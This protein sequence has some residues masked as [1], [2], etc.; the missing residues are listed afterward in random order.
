M[1]T[2]TR[3]WTQAQRFLRRP[4]KI[5]VPILTGLIQAAGVDIDQCLVTTGE[6]Q[7]RIQQQALAM[8]QIQEYNKRCLDDPTLPKIFLISGRD[9]R[10]GLASCYFLGVHDWSVAEYGGVF[11]H[12]ITG[13]IIDN[14]ALAP[15]T[16]LAF[17]EV[18][19]IAETIPDR[20]PGLRLYRGKSVMVT[21]E[22]I[23][24]T[25]VAM[26]ILVGLVKSELQDYENIVDILASQIAVDILPKG[27]NKGVGVQIRYES[28]LAVVQ[29]SRTLVIDDSM[30]GAAAATM[31]GFAGC[32]SNATL[33]Y[34]EFIRSIGGHVSKRPLREGVVDI[35][36]HFGI[37]IRG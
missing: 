15:K 32:P 8:A 6:P 26:D 22:R 9:I 33:E 35:M 4:R 13:D 36:Q 3:P 11:Y 24:D 12:P 37:K 31:A 29:P 14:K 34:R 16:Y 10:Y 17:Q 21:L 23:P 1:E 27:I 5:R 7:T 2:K 28:G 25:N 19:R 18:R 20:V 30:G